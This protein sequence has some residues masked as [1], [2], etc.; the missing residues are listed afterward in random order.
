MLLIFLTSLKNQR[1][2]CGMPRVGV[3]CH[4]RHLRIAKPCL[5]GGDRGFLGGVA[6]VVVVLRLVKSGMLSLCC[7]KHN[8]SVI[9][10]PVFPM[11]EAQIHQN[12]VPYPSTIQG[13]GK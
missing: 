5:L 4:Y 9:I 1:L 8:T 3:S 7:C 13:V 10:Y 11:A 12:K 6:T 2:G